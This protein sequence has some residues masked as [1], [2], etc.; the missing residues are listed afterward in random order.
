M[1]PQLFEL[2]ELNRRMANLFRPGLVAAVDH[3][4][5]RVRVQSGELLTAWLPW[6]TQRAGDDRDWWPLEVGEQVLILC[7][8]G[9]PA[10]GW[11][12]G[13]SYTQSRPAPSADPDKRR[14][15]F[16]DGAAYEYD[17]K[18]HHFDI[19]LPAGATVTFLADG[20][21]TLTGDVQVNGSI[22]ATGDITDQTRSMAAD[23]AIY[24]SHVHPGVTAGPAK[25][26]AT[27]ESQ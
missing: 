27:G 9:D 10:Q 8:N 26:G 13:S 3:Q 21:F 16:A 7:P 20:G 4:R 11:V 12:L 23:R 22:T 6:L 5:A 24:N 19:H 17:R 15:T 2:A 1:N 18:R 14:G 25:T